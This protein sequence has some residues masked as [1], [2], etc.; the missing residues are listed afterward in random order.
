M[1]SE[2]RVVIESRSQQ[3]VNVSV[4][5]D[6]GKPVALK[7]MPG[8]G[9]AAFR[10]DQITPITHQLAAAGHISLRSV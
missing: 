10:Y 5:D 9:T 7:L 1:P 4:V 6:S 8:A 2:A 3:A